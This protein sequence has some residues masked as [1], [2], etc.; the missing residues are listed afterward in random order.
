MLICPSSG[1][2][3]FKESS[4]SGF[5]TSVDNVQSEPRIRMKSSSHQ[6]QVALTGTNQTRISA[7]LLS[8]RSRSKILPTIALRA[9]MTSPR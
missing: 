4:R 6:L 7:A 5:E 1:S 3:L 9:R 2:S 8:C